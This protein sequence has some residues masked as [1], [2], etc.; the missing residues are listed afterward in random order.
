MPSGDLWAHPVPLNNPCEE[1]QL[2][3]R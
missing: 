3:W 1:T 2:K